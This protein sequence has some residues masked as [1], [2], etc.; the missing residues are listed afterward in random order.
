MPE[1]PDEQIA[2]LP[3]EYREAYLT[4]R[5]IYVAER[6][7][8]LGRTVLARVA[9][10]VLASVCVAGDLL[11]VWPLFDLDLWTVLVEKW[12]RDNDRDIHAGGW[13]RD[14]VAAALAEAEPNH[15]LWLHFELVHVRGFRQFCPIQRLGGSARPRG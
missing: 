12:V 6:A 2:A 10:D 14:A 8:F 9:P 7:R 1:L 15:P 4:L 3:T 11:A 13:G 5:C